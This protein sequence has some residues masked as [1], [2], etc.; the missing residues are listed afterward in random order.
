[1]PGPIVV[2]SIR[3]RGSEL[4]RI[5][6]EYA[7]DAIGTLGNACFFDADRAWVLEH[8]AGSLAEVETATLRLVA[9]RQ[10][11]SIYAAAARLGMS[12][13]ALGQWFKRHRDGEAQR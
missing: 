4:T 6:D 12:H 8:A 9:I 3:E 10:A 2:P 1:V 7:L 5:V 13:V 11:G